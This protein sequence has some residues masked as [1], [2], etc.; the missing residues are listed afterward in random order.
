MIISLL[1]PSRSRCD[2]AVEAFANWINKSSGKHTIEYYCSI[3]DTDPQKDY[4]KE[5]FSDEVL[6][7]N[8]NRSIVDAVNIAALQCKGDLI[9][10]MSDDFDCPDDWDDLLLR[11]LVVVD[12]FDITPVGILIN[13]G[14][15]QECMTLPILNRSAYK[16]IGH[17]YHPGYFS[18]FADNE[19]TDVLRKIGVMVEA[20]ELLFRHNHYS[21]PGGLP[22]DAT[23]KRENSKSAYVIGQKLYEQRKLTNFA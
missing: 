10:V 13:D 7:I 14:I 1:H 2:I 22:E 3:D 16:A 8:D 15:Q 11:K 23:Y 5:R 9:V 21:V 19:L 4:Y 20:P 17:V 12:N 18:M 6:L